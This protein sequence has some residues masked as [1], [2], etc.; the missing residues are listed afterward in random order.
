MKKGVAITTTFITSCRLPPTILFIYNN[1]GCFF[2]HEKT[3]CRKYK[4]I[5]A[6]M[7]YINF[8]IY[9]YNIQNVHFLDIFCCKNITV[10]NFCRINTY[11]MAI[12]KL[13]CLDHVINIFLH[14][15]Q[16]S[17]RVLNFVGK[18]SLGDT[19]CKVWDLCASNDHFKR[20]C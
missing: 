2:N 19:W 9:F 12:C 14:D 4:F 6:I 5:V 10:Q 15:I 8:Y 1:N 20:G 18:F 3:M 11:Q 17:F 13:H 7:N 16:I